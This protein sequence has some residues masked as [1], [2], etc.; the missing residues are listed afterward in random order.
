[1]RWECRGKGILTHRYAHSN[2]LTDKFDWPDVKEYGPLPTVQTQPSVAGGERFPPRR[3]TAMSPAL[4]NLATQVHALLLRPGNLDATRRLAEA[5]LAD[6]EQ[7]RVDALQLPRHP[8]YHLYEPDPWER[9][10][11]FEGSPTLLPGQMAL[12]LAALHDVGCSHVEKVISIPAD[13]HTLN[14]PNAPG[15]DDLWLI[16]N[17]YGRGQRWLVIRDR[18]S[19]L[20]DHAVDWFNPL[21]GSFERLLSELVRPPSGSADDGAADAEQTS[22]AARAIA[23][24]LEAQ[25]DGRPVPP[26]KDLARMVGCDRSTLFRDPQFKAVRKALTEG[27]LSIP[28]GQ[29]MDSGEIDA[30]TD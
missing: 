23:L 19:G 20:G 5:C 15:R 8:D 28:R 4:I 13:A 7:G 2:D 10:T 22:P 16:S 6:P 1:M 24:M 25:R 26:V 29:R 17:D 9:E 21:L 14:P 12:A 30:E 3:A 18:V 11:S 27:P